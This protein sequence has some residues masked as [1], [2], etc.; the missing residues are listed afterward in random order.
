MFCKPVPP[1]VCAS[2]VSLSLAEE[3]AHNT[4]RTSKPTNHQP[5]L[6]F[7]AFHHLRRPPPRRLPPPPPSLQL[8]LKKKK[9]ERWATWL[10]WWGYIVSL[11]LFLFLYI[12]FGFF[13][14]IRAAF[15][16]V[17]SAGY[18]SSLRSTIVDATTTFRRTSPLTHILFIL[19]YFFFLLGRILRFSLPL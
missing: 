16:T 12:H 6:F 13:I 7:T 14:I 9:D 8:F 1:F 2:W 19:F 18:I 3:G 11:S 17:G 5:S 10:L 15:R 4:S